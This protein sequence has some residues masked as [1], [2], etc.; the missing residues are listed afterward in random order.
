MSAGKDR[1]RSDNERSSVLA[2]TEDSFVSRLAGALEAMGYEVERQSQLKGRSG[3]EHRF[4]IVVKKKKEGKFLETIA[5][6]V[7][8]APAGK[9]EAS[10][11]RYFAM[12]Y[13]VNP[14]RVFIVSSRS[15]SESANKLASMY[16]LCVIEESSAERAAQELSRI[17]I[18]A[19]GVTSPKR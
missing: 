19:I 3:V 2:L 7:E 6:V 13:D 14:V 16:K 17:M 18:K 1:N 9:D 11:I 15:L 12:S 4:D 10:I 5:I 8:G